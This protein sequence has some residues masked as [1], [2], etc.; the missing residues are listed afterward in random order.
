MSKG[1][2]VPSASHLTE[3]VPGPT[4]TWKDRFRLIDTCDAKAHVEAPHLDRGPDAQARARHGRLLRG[5]AAA[6]LAR[7]RGAHGLLAVRGCGAP[8]SRLPR[9]R[10]MLSCWVAHPRPRGAPRLTYV[11]YGRSVGKALDTFGLDRNKWP[12]LA[13]DHLAWRAMLRSGVRRAV[14]RGVSGQGSSTAGS[15]ETATKRS[16]FDKRDEG[17]R[18]R[19]ALGV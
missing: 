9:A 4:R 17:S 19:R 15:L 6:R 1:G 10:R 2:V 11:G 7:P 12:E 14:P 5:V 13:A 16:L 3:N 8:Y 18:R